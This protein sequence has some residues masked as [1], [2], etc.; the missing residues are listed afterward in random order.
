MGK[1]WAAKSCVRQALQFQGGSRWRFTFARPEQVWSGTS[2]HTAAALTLWREPR[3][4]QSGNKH[5]GVSHTIRRLGVRS[6]EGGLYPTKKC[7]FWQRINAKNLLLPLGWGPRVGTNKFPQLAHEQLESLCSRHTEAL[8]LPRSRERRRFRT[9][10]EKGQ[11][12][13]SGCADNS[14]V[15]DKCKLGCLLARLT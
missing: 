2:L 1:S 13:D 11:S 8:Q 9:R 3:L 14:M 7:N 10:K 6:F 4:L 5:H 15:V 12:V